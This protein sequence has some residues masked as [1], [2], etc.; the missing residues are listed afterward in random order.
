[1]HDSLDLFGEAALRIRGEVGLHL[2]IGLVKL[3]FLEINVGELDLYVLM[4]RWVER[5]RL[6]EALLGFCE[7]TEA[8]ARNPQL[9][10]KLPGGRG[11]ARSLR[12]FRDARPVVLL[13]II[14]QAQLEVSIRVAGVA[15]DG[16]LERRFCLLSSRS[17]PR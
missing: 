1:M 7:L 10:I 11:V 15:L 8:E 13:G 16:L 14:N 17:A 6:E 3:A 4:L 9:I 2:R 12:Q 5:P